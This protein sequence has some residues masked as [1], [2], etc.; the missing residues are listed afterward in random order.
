M[1]KFPGNPALI[2]FEKY[3]VLGYNIRLNNEKVS[4]SYL[5]PH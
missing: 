3:W 1:P 5:R 2:L 4:S